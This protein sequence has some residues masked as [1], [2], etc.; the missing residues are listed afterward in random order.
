VN[1]LNALV[2]GLIMS[3]HP[4]PLPPGMYVTTPPYTRPTPAR[5]F[6]QEQWRNS[7]LREADRFCT[8]YGRDPVCRRQPQ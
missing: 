2:A 7:I 8:A 6:S 4:V 3:A 1:S 5:G